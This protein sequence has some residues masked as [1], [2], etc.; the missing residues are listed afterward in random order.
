V[1]GPSEGAAAAAAAAGAGAAAH[2]NLSVCL[3]LL[4]PQVA[5]DHWKGEAKGRDSSTTFQAEGVDMLLFN[6][7][8]Q[9]TTLVQF[10]MQNYSKQLRGAGAVDAPEGRST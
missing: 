4:L 8:G 5:F 3:L 2:L 9:I 6:K 10:D 1:A 7:E